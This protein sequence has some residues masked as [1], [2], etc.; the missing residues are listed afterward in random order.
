MLS[1]HWV[2]V[3]VLWNFS[4]KIIHA[5]KNVSQSTRQWKRTPRYTD[6]LSDQLTGCGTMHLCN[7]W[8]KYL[9]SNWLWKQM[10]DSKGVTAIQCRLQS[11]YRSSQNCF[12]NFTKTS[13][14]KNSSWTTCACCKKSKRNDRNKKVQEEL[15][16]SKCECG[17]HLL[18]SRMISSRVIWSSGSKSLIITSGACVQV[19]VC[20]VCVWVCVCVSP[21]ALERRYHHALDKSPRSSWQ[22]TGVAPPSGNS[23]DHL[24]RR[25]RRRGRRTDW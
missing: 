10:T 23:E 19:H 7:L 21:A 2:H 15:G 13:L 3:C 18:S 20:C 11:I 1:A 6:L 14:T 9:D 17:P 16:L 8:L 4:W 12:V 25:R 22:P 24:V 5:F